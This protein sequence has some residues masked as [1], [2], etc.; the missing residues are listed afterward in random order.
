M[1]KGFQ[2]DQPYFWY[3]SR[4]LERKQ[5]N[6]RE[7]RGNEGEKTGETEKKNVTQHEKPGHPFE[8]CHQL[9][10]LIEWQEEKMEH[11]V[12]AEKMVHN[13]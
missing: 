9:S 1:S 7:K 12:F 4:K 5:R 8:S 10:A 3:A 6:M 13:E 2:R 11:D